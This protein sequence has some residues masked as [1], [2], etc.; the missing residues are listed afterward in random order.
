MGRDTT[1]G[2]FPSCGDA[3][4][5]ST[6][7]LDPL[8]R[9]TSCEDGTRGWPLRPAACCW[10]KTPPS[11]RDPRRSGSKSPVRP[12]SRPRRMAAPSLARPL[13]ASPDRAAPCPY[14]RASRADRF[15]RRL[16]CP[17]AHLRSGWP[18]ECPIRP[19]GWDNQPSPQA[20]ASSQSARAARHAFCLRHGARLGPAIRMRSAVCFD[21]SGKLS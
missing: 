15:E 10:S 13:G 4:A 20:R 17:P 12:R 1:N 2:L 9:K 3:V 7:G 16:P 11:K 19:G 8:H 5:G 6:P 18:W 21:L 14:A